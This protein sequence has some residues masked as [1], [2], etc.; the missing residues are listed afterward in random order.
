MTSDEIK[1]L[2][3]EY[4]LP[5]YARFDLC[6]TQGS[7][8]TATSPEGKHY[9]DF[10]SGIGVNSLGWA[11]PQWAEAV[12]NQAATLQH[13]SNIYYTLPAAQLAQALCRRTGMDKV[14]FANSGA[15]ANEGAIK[16]ARKYSLMKYG[17]GRA[18]ILTL[19]NSF[20]GRTLATLTATGQDVFHQHFHPF[21]RG[22]AYTPAD[23]IPALEAA[24]TPDVC[25][26][27]LEPVQ[28]EG[29]V[30]PLQPEFLAHAQALCRSKD[31]L[32][33]ADEVQTGI[34]RT[35]SFLASTQLGLQPDIITLAKGLGGGLPLGAVLFAKHCAT[36]LGKGDHAT[37]YGANPV[38]CAGAL[39]VLNTL[40]DSFLQ[41][42]REK[43]RLLIQGLQQLPGVEQV[44]GMG[45]MLGI[46]FRE[47]ITAAQVLQAA[48]DKGMLCLLAKHKL[49]LLPPLTITPDEITAGLQI[50]QQV[51][52][53][54]A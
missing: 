44:T 45:L 38:C 9:L 33:I 10:T 34:G 3:D 13:T 21:P 4:I 17:E 8:C 53:E 23:D 27:L 31:I 42:V 2:T 30:V 7:G 6:L 48:M 25:A 49:R 35:G 52:E 5:T 43:S 26:L 16:A 50:L 19:Q 46:T 28:G 22:F 1:Q 32:L 47:G 36:A 11:H 18:T 41:Q 20:H 14:F 15:E 29:G 39:V 40:T 24:L 12:A 37:T 54:I 51:L